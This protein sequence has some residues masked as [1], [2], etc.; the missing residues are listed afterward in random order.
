MRC[1]NPDQAFTGRQPQWLA[2]G[3]QFLEALWAVRHDQ[4]RQRRPG[5]VQ[6]T[7]VVFG[8]TPIDPDVNWHIYRPPGVLSGGPSADAGYRVPVMAL[9]WRGTLW[10]VRPDWP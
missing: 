3:V 2:Q 8:L 1:F 10:T 4:T 6:D 7:H 5:R 9:K